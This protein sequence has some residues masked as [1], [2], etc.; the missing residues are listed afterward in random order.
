[1]GVKYN[2]SRILHLRSFHINNIFLGLCS[3]KIC[4]MRIFKKS[5]D[6]VVIDCLRD[7]CNHQITMIEC[8]RAIADK[9]ETQM[10]ER[11]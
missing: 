8:Y 5:F 6:D 2:G 1:M 11:K 4:K 3:R 9:H 10:G 7:L